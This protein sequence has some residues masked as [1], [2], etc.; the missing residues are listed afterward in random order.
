M[1]REIKIDF[2]PD[3]VLMYLRKSQADD[4]LMSVD[5]VL[6]KHERMLDDWSDRNLR[7][8]IPTEN[9][10][11][12]IVSGETLKDR[13]EVNKLLRRIESPRIRAVI[14]VEPQRLSRGDL[15]DIGRITK[16]LKH[17]NTL[18]ITPYKTYDLV[19]EYD[20]DAFERELKRGNE[21]LEYYKKIQARGKLL[22]VSDGNYIGSKPPYGY[23]KIA[24]N[25]GGK[26][27]R[28]TLIE[29]K[30]QADVVRLIFDLYAN[31][32]L[33]QQ[34]ICNHLN[35][36]G[37]KAP[38]G[39][40]WSCNSI[41][42]MVSNVH[43]IGK[44][45]WNWRKGVVTVEDGEFKR[46]RP[47][48]KVGDYLVFDGKH[49]GIVSEELFNKAQERKGRN[50][51][52][53]ARNAMKNP[54]AGLLYCQCGRAMQIK[55][56]EGERARYVCPDQRN[57]GTGSCLYDD[58]M[59]R[60]VIALEQ[61]LDDFIVFDEHDDADRS[62]QQTAIINSLEKRLEELKE[63]E[64][65]QWEAQSDPDES[66]RM[67][68]A[69]FKA[70]NERLL[71]ERESIQEA[72]KNARETVSEP[73]VRESKIVTLQTALDA[74]LDGGTDAAKK[75]MFLRSCIEKIVYDREKPKRMNGQNWSDTPIK[76]DIT[77]KF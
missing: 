19:D 47:K 2:T 74:L 49:E 28:H 14:V 6:E 48:A 58:V 5:E 75:N 53:K 35:A 17:T 13:P 64:I 52:V 15:E 26:R 63:R 22:S 16:L 10:Y 25:D 30:E 31:Q 44:V 69:V 8:R 66:N 7:G 72:L 20:R 67:P 45:K 11:R 62:K 9:R 34:R 36:L 23:D 65:A 56:R 54:L 33:G 29:N 37:I 4:P 50:P 60:V 68:K 40:H 3:D 77:M 32:G 71:A 51:R 39:K 41:V 61:S 70:L 57:C 38:N 73:L 76:L 12:E 59:D 24:I 42:D 43:Y 21:Y 1:Y 46:S 55:E 27:T 18:V